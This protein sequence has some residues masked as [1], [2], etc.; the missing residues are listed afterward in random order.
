MG[1]CSRLPRSTVSRFS[2]AGCTVKFR[3]AD[4]EDFGHYRFDLLENLVRRRSPQD[5]L[6]QFIGPPQHF[7]LPA[8]P[9]VAAPDDE[10]TDTTAKTAEAPPVTCPS[11]EVT[12]SCP[13]TTIIPL[14]GVRHLG[15]QPCF[16]PRAQKI[17]D[18]EI[19]ARQLAV[20]GS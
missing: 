18:L 7:P 15:P 4:A 8:E 17:V 16:E 3:A 14:Q 11:T 2:R 9:F 1:V 20:R 10:D 12:S 5:L 13:V 6:A 19:R